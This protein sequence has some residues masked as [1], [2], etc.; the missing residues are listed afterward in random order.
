V[1]AVVGTGFKPPLRGLAIVARELVEEAGC[2]GGCGGPA[3]RVGCGLDGADGG[4]GVSRGCGGDVYAAEDG[5]CL[6]A[7]DGATFGPVVVAEIGSP[8]AAVVVSTSG[9]HW[10]GSAKAIAEGRAM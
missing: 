2:A 9:M 5:A 4:G 1:D 10:A 7:S 8:A 6:W 3:E